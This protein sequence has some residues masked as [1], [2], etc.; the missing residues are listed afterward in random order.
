[1]ALI[2]V[3]QR[4][5]VTAAAERLYCSQP[6]VTKQLKALEKELGYSLFV[7]GKKGLVI[8]SKG[9]IVFERAMNIMNEIKGI[10]SDLA[11]TEEGVTGTVM[12]GCGPVFA[13][14]ILPRT[15]LACQRIHP[16]MKFVFKESS[17]LD[18]ADLLLGDEIRL[19]LGMD[20]LDNPS[21]EFE[22]L[23]S[24]NL[25]LALPEKHPLSGKKSIRLSLKEL[26][27]KQKSDLKV[28]D[29]IN[30]A[31][32]HAKV[33]KWL[34]RH[35]KNTSSIQLQNTETILEFVSKGLGISLVPSY[36]VSLLKRKD[37]V[38]KQLKEQMSLQFGIYR[39]RKVLLSR[40]EH[41]FIQILKDTL[42]DLSGIEF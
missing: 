32:R 36:L 24:D 21:I 34:I 39:K 2:E 14:T 22:P 8:T 15:I 40:T 37:I 3:A 25:V 26:S 10:H 1:M 9:S 33:P 19:S 5:S 7:K 30:D 27:E 17:Y 13:R 18:Q 41:A 12:L 42:P 29:Y 35:L 20:L 11:E 16:E 23:F 31:T 6:A 4:G 28:P 38:V